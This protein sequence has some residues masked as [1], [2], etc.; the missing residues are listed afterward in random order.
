MLHSV[1]VITNF[2]IPQRDKK[3][4]KKITLFRLQPAREPRSPAYLAR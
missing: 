3:T 2:V 4:N 1:Y